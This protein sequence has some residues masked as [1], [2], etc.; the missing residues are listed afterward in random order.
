MNLDSI[1]FE[2]GVII[3]GSA[4]LGTLFLYTKQPIVIAY[5]AIGFIVGPNGLALIQST[6]HIEEIAHLGIILL[7]F[8]VGLNLQPQKLLHIFRKTAL[9]TF[10]TSLVFATQV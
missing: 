3:F 5:I 10:S 2:L 9:L 1:I 4:V 8:L 7:L 6:E